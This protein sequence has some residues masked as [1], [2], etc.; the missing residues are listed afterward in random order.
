[1]RRFLA[2]CLTGDT[3][4]LGAALHQ[5]AVAT[6]DGGGAVLA[7]LNPV[8]GAENVAALVSVLLCVP[9]TELTLAAVN[10]RAG[11]A[12]RRAGRAEAVV[13]TDCAGDLVAALWIV[14]NPAKLSRWHVTTEH[15]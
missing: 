12:L 6:C 15:G 7:A 8:H 11:L 3:A 10:G 4:A 1:M 9:G 14:L 5:D 2:A 13:A